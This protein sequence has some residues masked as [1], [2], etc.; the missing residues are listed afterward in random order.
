MRPENF[1]E[2][3]RTWLVIADGT[4]NLSSLLRTRGWR[5][6]SRMFRSGEKGQV[7][8]WMKGAGMV[9]SLTSVCGLMTTP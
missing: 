3:W 1:L 5:F 9:R 6:F 7:G 8:V 2:V 4:K